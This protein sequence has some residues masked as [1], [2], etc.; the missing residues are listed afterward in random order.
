MNKQDIDVQERIN[1]IQELNY[2]I[3]SID[4]FITTFSNACT[5]PRVGMKSIFKSFIRV[6]SSKEISFMGSADFRVGEHNY[7]IELPYDLRGKFLLWAEEEIARLRKE[8]DLLTQGVTIS[9]E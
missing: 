4:Y 8:V 2:R 7:D 5:E 3:R 6:T 1:Y 9:E